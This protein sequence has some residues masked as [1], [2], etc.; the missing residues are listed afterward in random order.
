VNTVM[1]TLYEVL[2]AVLLKFK[3]V[4]VVSGLSLD[5]SGGPNGG[6]RAGDLIGPRDPEDQGIRIVRN[7]RNCL[8][9]DTA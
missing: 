3:S 2:T 4:R 1:N 8:P 9:S 7:V 6:G 5:K